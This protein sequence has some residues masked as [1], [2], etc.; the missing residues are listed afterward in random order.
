MSSSPPLYQYQG[1]CELLLDRHTLR[2]VHAGGDQQG[3]DILLLRHGPVLLYIIEAD[4][5]GGVIGSVINVGVP[6][7][8][9]VEPAP[10]NVGEQGAKGDAHQQ[11]RL[12]FLVNAQ[13]EQDAGYGDHNEILP[14]ACGEESGKAGVLHQPS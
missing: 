5:V 3:I 11:Q 13:V 14:A 2:T 8:H 9:V 4:L 6:H 12:K 7:L 1:L 10:G